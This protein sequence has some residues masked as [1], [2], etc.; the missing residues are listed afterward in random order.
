MATRPYLCVD[1]GKRH[2]GQQ[3]RCRA[4]KSAFRRLPDHAARCREE[5]AA[6]LSGAKSF[7]SPQG[8]GSR[9][10]SLRDST[11]GRDKAD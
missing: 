9:K 5:S 4:C 7:A 8:A 3:G 2:Q 11:P 10:T 1:C 6:R